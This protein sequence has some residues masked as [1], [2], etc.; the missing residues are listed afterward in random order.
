MYEAGMLLLLVNH[1]RACIAWRG[2][3]CMVVWRVRLFD[4]GACSCRRLRQWH[5]RGL[6]VQALKEQA[7]MV[8]R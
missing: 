6:G 8:E 4:S 3:K 5:R 2:K 1:T 7:D